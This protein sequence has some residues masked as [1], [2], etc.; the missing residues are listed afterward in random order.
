VAG[1][2]MASRKVKIGSNGG[3]VVGSTGEETYPSR[4]ARRQALDAKQFPGHMPITNPLKGID[5]RVAPGR[6]VVCVVPGRIPDSAWETPS[7]GDGRPARAVASG[8]C[9]RSAISQRG[10]WK[11]F[12]R[13]LG[14]R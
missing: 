1:H 14:L 3:P 10:R 5:C 11:P 9:W 2:D 4:E 6:P 13:L 7:V 8:R 12:R